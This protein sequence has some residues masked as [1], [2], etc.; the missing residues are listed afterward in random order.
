MKL[1]EDGA[2]AFKHVGVFTLYEIVLIY[3]YVC[4]YYIYIYIYIIY[5]LCRAFVGLDN[6]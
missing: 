5:I 1:P 3:I 2:D 4:V 6:K